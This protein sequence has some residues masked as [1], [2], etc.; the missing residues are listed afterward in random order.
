MKRLAIVLGCALALPACSQWKATAR[1]NP[2]TVAVYPG[3][4]GPK[5][6]AR[7]GGDATDCPLTGGYSDTKRGAV[8]LDCFRFPESTGVTPLGPPAYDL[9]VPAPPPEPARAKAAR[10]AAAT[11]RNRLAAVL[12]KQ[13]DDICVLEKGRLV[14]TE[15]SANFLLSFITQAVSGASTIVSGERAKSILSGIATLSS[16]TQDNVNATFYR[17]QLIQAINKALDRERANIM[18]QINANRAR[19]IDAYTV[20]EMI[21]LVNSYHQACSF[22]RGLQ[23][24][25]DAALDSKGA[26]AALQNRSRDSAVQ[27]LKAQVAYLRTQ[28]EAAEDGSELEASLDKQIA[29][30]LAQITGIE[31]AAV[32]K[33][34]A[35]PSAGDTTEKHTTEE[36]KDPAPDG[37][38]K[39]QAGGK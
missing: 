33:S 17:N 10:E 16:G 15:S 24:L 14:A 5:L 12:V 37:G 7:H 27:K 38:K 18:V 6:A 11:A 2:S 19:D 23:V 31:T 25:L 36:K 26:E 9:A 4:I 28:R 13:A 20:D 32:E 35:Q 22:E 34:L 8:N 21:A 1:I 30:L 3:G 29:D 39:P